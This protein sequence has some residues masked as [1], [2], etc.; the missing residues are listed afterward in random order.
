[1]S[2]EYNILVCGSPRVGKSTLV[3]AMC[4]KSVAKT[5][6]RLGSCSDKMEKYVLRGG[7]EVAAA[8]SSEY[9]ISIWDTPGIESWTE[10]DIRSQI[11]AMVNASKPLCMIYCASPGSFARMDQLKW[12]IDTCVQSNIFC[13]FVCT[14]KYSGGSERRREVLLDFHSLLTPHHRLTDEQDSIQY[15]GDV[16][17][18]TSVNSIVYEDSDLNVRKNVEGINELIYGIMKSLQDDRL[19]A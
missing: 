4:G 18:C 19:V 2:R 9:A 15:F 10:K 6:D 5:S 11:S 14:N 16:G 7:D 12:L 1:M 17:L 3:N 13:A 8:S